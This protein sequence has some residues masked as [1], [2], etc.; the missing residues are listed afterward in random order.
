[1]LV[2][3]QTLFYIHPILILVLTLRAEH[4]CYPHF[5]FNIQERKRIHDD[6]IV[7]GDE[8]R[9]D[10]ALA[11]IGRRV[12]FYCDRR[13]KRGCVLMWWIMQVKRIQGSSSLITSIFLWRKRQF[14]C[15]EWEGRRESRRLESKDLAE[16]IEQRNV[17]L[18]GS[19]EGTFAFGVLVCSSQY[20]QMLG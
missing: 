13:N 9:E 1:M 16:C 6:I 2:T 12:P 7:L 11:A 14:H 3:C 15:L 10:W 18:V 20:I 19:A 8:I 4:N 5:T 17:E